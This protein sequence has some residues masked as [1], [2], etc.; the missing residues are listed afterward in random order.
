MAVYLG[1]SIYSAAEKAVNHF[2][3]LVTNQV[4]GNTNDTIAAQGQYGQGITVIAT[5][6]NKILSG[7]FNNLGDFAQITTGFLYP[8]NIVNTA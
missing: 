6:D 1:R 4:R 7:V 2:P 3:Y 5:P 8:D